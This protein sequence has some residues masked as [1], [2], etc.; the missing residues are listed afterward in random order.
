VVDLSLKMRET[1][2]KAVKRL[3]NGTVKSHT[4]VKEPKS[5]AC[6][7]GDRSNKGAGCDYSKYPGGICGKFYRVLQF[8]SR[9][10]KSLLEKGIC[11]CYY[12]THSD[13]VSPSA[14][15]ANMNV[16]EYLCSQYHMPDD[17]RITARSKPLQQEVYV[18]A[19]FQSSTKNFDCSVMLTS[20]KS[21]QH[22]V[23]GIFRV[24]RLFPDIVEFE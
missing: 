10:I 5:S 24:T 3:S 7:E 13:Y 8:S 22:P 2:T 6:N 12:S 4:F 1:A 19:S 21:F 16:N 20:V 15:G 17:A 23:K 18:D 14:N 9:R 11:F